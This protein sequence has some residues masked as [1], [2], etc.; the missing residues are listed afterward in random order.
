MASSLRFVVLDIET[1]HGVNF[2]AIRARGGFKPWTCE[3]WQD[4]YPAQVCAVSFE[5][6]EE[7]DRLSTTINWGKMAPPLDNPY[8]KHLTQDTI[9]LGVSPNSFFE[10][11]ATMCGHTESFVGYNVGFDMGCLR[12]HAA[13]YG[14]PLP[15]VPDVCLM[16]PAKERLGL[17]RWPKLVDAYRMLC[18]QEPSD[19]AHD[20]E[21]DVHMTCEVMKVLVLPATRQRGAP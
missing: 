8:C 9:D 19:M 13:R 17:T 16:D 2:G 7:K 20:A 18:G 1:L 6:G 14:N 11:L 10:M 5:D 4:V 21:Y 3:C 15:E 12:Y